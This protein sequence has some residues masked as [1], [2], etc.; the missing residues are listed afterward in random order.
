MQI[1]KTPAL[2]THIHQFDNM[3]CKYLQQPYR[4]SEMHGNVSRRLQQYMNLA[5]AASGVVKPSRCVV[6]ICVSEFGCIVR[7]CTTCSETDL[8]VGVFSI[9]IHVFT[10]VAARAW[11]SNPYNRTFPNTTVP[12]CGCN[13]ASGH[14]HIYLCI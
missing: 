6:S 3:C 5:G 11:C 13:S 1:E 14:T 2:R 9:C 10:T 12:P 8:F 7:I 4:N